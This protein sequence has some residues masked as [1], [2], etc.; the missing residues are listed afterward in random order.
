L[1]ANEALGMAIQ[2][3]HEVDAGTSMV[4]EAG[5]IMAQAAETVTGTGEG[6]DNNEQVL[7]GIKE[8]ADQF[9]AMFAALSPDHELVSV[10]AQ[11]EVK[12]EELVTHTNAVG[13]LLDQTVS[14]VLAAKQGLEELVG[15]L[16]INK[17]GLEELQGL[18][19]LLQ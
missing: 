13:E 4:T 3:A 12:A 5:D 19:A 11:I 14:R 6:L 10:A 18:L 7:A 2:A 8:F 17:Q 9:G 16:Q 15:Q 1:N